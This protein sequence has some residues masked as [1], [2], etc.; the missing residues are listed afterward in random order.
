MTAVR[1]E[2]RIKTMLTER[3]IVGGPPGE[4]DETGSLIDLYGVDSVSMLEMIVGLE[5]EFG[6]AVGDAD[7]ALERFQSVKA[8][9]DFVRDRLKPE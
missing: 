2:D 7:F 6:I 5:E 8:I 4:I 1:I 9:A 3:F